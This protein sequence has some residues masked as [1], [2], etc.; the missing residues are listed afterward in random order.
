MWITPEGS[1]IAIITFCSAGFAFVFYPPETHSTLTQFTQIWFRICT[2]YTAFVE[3]LCYKR[4]KIKWTL[5]G[6]ACCGA[7]KRLNSEVTHR[8]HTLCCSYGGDPLECSSLPYVPNP[9]DMT[10]CLLV[11]P[12]SHRNQCAL[13]PQHDRT[14]S[15]L[16]GWNNTDW[17]TSYRSMQ[18]H[19]QVQTAVRP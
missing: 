17:T 10:S 14:R 13:L 18:F 8:N 6:S 4:K 2:G 1:S 12:M 5:D 3:V 16:K 15:L 9:C 19:Y 11:F 7:I